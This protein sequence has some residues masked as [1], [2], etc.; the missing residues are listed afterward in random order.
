M[1]TDRQHW[2][3]VIG[4]ILAAVGSAVG[5]GNIW[6]FPYVTGQNGGGAFVLIYL[7]SIALVGLPIMIAEMK[8]GRRTNHGPV[9]AFAALARE[10][11]GGANW[12]YLG[13]FAVFT[14]IILL[15]Y[16]SVVGGWTLE[17]TRKALLAEFGAAGP[18]QAP[19]MFGELVGAPV[20]QLIWHLLFMGLAIG[21][22]RGGVSD[23]IEKAA[24]IL[25]PAFGLLLISLFI[26]ALTT[27]GSGEAFE[28]MF[29]PNMENFGI[30]SILP[31]VGQSFFTLS[32]GMG[33]ILVYGSYLSKDD[34]I[35]QASISVAITD[36][37]VALMA[38]VVMFSIIF[39]QGVEPAQG[40]GLAFKVMPQLFAQMPGGAIIGI[41]F[42]LLLSF[43]AITSAISI[44]EVTTSYFIEEWD[45]DRKTAVTY[46]G[47]GIAVLGIPSILGFNVLS[48]MTLTLG[49]EDKNILSILDY[50]CVN[51]ALPI[52]G[53]AVATYAGW[54]VDPAQWEDEVKD[55]PLAKYMLS[56]WFILIRYIALPAVLVMLASKIG[57][58]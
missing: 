1:E 34:S 17:Y 10:K 31:A 13:F 20:H 47:L 39:S 52:G 36:T 54:A 26:Y 49:G 12:K 11:L 21:I 38:G 29:C 56:G 43:A 2:T 28:F 30:N 48:D 40:P 18:E 58:F 4:F 6:R 19:K 14:A 16:Y 32:L 9:G 42:F 55:D 24:K 8:I 46:F 41:V 35:Y 37:L 25:M 50:F 7:T 53:L 51:F 15:S 5:L 22:V 57:I 45:L 33:T 23:G 44:L 27:S 3:G